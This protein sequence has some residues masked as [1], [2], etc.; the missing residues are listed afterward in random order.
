MGIANLKIRKKD[1]LKQ[2]TFSELI[3]ALAVTKPVPH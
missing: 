2:Y 1:I 3:K